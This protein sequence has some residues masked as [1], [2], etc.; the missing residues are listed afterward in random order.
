M[1]I[2]LVVALAA[3][4]SPSVSFDDAQAAELA[5]NCERFVRCGLYVDE[6][7][8]ETDTRQVTD[9]N[10]AAAV[11]SGAIDYDGA[12][13][14]QCF[15]ALA[16][17]SC[18]STTDAART[19]PTPCTKIFSGTVADGDPCAFDGEC[20][21]QTCVYPTV[22][23]EGT[24]CAGT[25]QTPTPAAVGGTCQ[26]T[27]DCMA[28]A[29]CSTDHVCTALGAANDTCFAD[30]ECEDGLGCILTAFPGICKTLPPLGGACPDKRCADIGEVCDATMTCVAAGLPGAACTTDSDCSPF[31]PCDQATK[32]CADLPDVGLPC[33][34]SCVG[35]AWCD[36]T[37]TP[38]TCKAP[39]DNLAPCNSDDECD[40]N[41]CEDGPAF[42]SCMP[43]PT[44][45]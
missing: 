34:G 23:A 28:P 42:D 27:K 29:Y 18:D 3:C 9:Q 36:L 11:A 6:A 2:G 13:A 17:I 15:D 35:N 38:G 8:C 40:S 12:Q 31:A 5:A 21:G 24:C 7:T 10:L 37:N 20:D 25:C 14:K 45:T 16:A 43:L 26:V 1:R 32:Q 30:S 22:C 4:H 33:T 41:F 19:L 39:L 44:C